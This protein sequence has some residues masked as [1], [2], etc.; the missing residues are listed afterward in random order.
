[1]KFCKNGR[2]IEKAA[3]MPASGFLLIYSSLTMFEITHF[4]N[5]KKIEAGIFASHGPSRFFQVLEA[6]NF[7]MDSLFFLVIIQNKVNRDIVFASSLT[8]PGF[9]EATRFPDNPYP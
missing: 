1:M 4:H 9:L 8:F 2:K 6:H 3:V 5:A 7:F